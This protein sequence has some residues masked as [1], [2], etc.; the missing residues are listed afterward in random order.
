MADKPFVQFA[1]HYDAFMRRYVDYPDWV[2][3]VERVF[4]RFRRKPE[5]VL[6]VACGTGIPTVLLARRGYRMTGVDRSAEMLAVLEAKRGDLP[7]R[8]VRADITA[9]ELEGPVDVAIS[10]Y[11]SINYLLD[12]EDLK[13]CFACVHR[14][15]VP[16]G[17]FA[18][19]MNTM[20]GLAEFWGNRA[21]P[22]R[23][24][25]ISSI[26]QNGY[27]PAT[28]ISTLHLSFWEEPGEGPAPPR[29]EEVHQERAY[30]RS[31]VRDCLTAAGFER[32][33]F[34]SHGGFL[35]VGPFTTRMMVVAR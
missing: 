8:T 30:E 11:D 24:G 12:I 2:G 17:L 34:Y 26:W 15:L 7:I 23:V 35:P 19:D 25:N 18:F 9:F 32:V 28:R 33:N 10:L 27:D 5:T 3:Y 20:Y 6:D 16:G 13:R 22:R 31:E 21:V 1:R 14:A 4:R 29:F